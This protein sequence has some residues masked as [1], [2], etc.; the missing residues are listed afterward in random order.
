MI[1]DNAFRNLISA[2]K[3]TVNMHTYIIKKELLI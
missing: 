1:E 3:K 2:R